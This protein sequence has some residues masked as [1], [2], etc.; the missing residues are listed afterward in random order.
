MSPRD[1]IYFL[2]WKD[3]DSKTHVHRDTCPNQGKTSKTPSFCG[4][5]GHLAF[6]S[7]DS[8][9]GQL[10]AILRAHLETTTLPTTGDPVPYPAAHPAVKRCL[11]GVTEEQLKAR[12]IPKQAEPIFICDLSALCQV[13][14]S[15]LR[16]ASTDPIHLYI[17]SRDL[18]YFKLHFFSGDRPSD[19][20]VKALDDYMTICQGIRISVSTGP[21]FRA[22]CGQSVLIDAFSTDAAEARLKTYLTAAGL[23]NKTLYSFRCGGAITMALTGS[24]LDDIVDHVGWRSHN[25]AKYYLQ[26]HKS[27]QPASVA[28]MALVTPETTAQ[29]E[30]LNQLNGFEPAFSQNTTVTLPSKRQSPRKC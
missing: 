9:V 14:D 19:C 1:I 20:P 6:K 22:T 15:K 8:Y 4:C 16:S 7:V 21:L 28:K 2:I 25:M 3:K 12:A 18:A 13:M 27:L 26:L 17:Y 5:P 10:R 11:K 30:E 23:S 29:Y 24:M